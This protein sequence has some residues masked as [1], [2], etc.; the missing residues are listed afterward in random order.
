MFI[1]SALSKVNI[2]QS[3]TVLTICRHMYYFYFY[4]E[5]HPIVPILK[6]PLEVALSISLYG[7]A[8]AGTKRGL[9]GV[10]GISQG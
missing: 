4:M 7:A 2:P 8:L 6:Y 3:I 5:R 10:A 1:L 9:W